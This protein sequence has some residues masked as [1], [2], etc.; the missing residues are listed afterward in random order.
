MISHSVAG[1]GP[2]TY[3]YIASG[4]FISLRNHKQPVINKAVSLTVHPGV[5]DG[6]KSFRFIRTY[7]L[8]SLWI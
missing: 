2:S 8:E 1:F 5:N 4:Y 3:I 7:R 6:S